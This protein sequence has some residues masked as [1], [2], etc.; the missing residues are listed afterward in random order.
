MRAWCGEA[1]E[2]GRFD[3]SEV[4]ERLERLKV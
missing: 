4:N 3:L 1:F 2:P